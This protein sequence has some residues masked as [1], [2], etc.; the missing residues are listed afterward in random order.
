M[1]WQLSEWNARFSEIPIAMSEA[2]IVAGIR[3]LRTNNYPK[4]NDCPLRSCPKYRPA[5]SFD[6]CNIAVGMCGDF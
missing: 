3:Y 2:K 6:I 4:P 1:S 5:C